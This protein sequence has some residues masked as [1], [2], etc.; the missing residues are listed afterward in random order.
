[1]VKL[2][3]EPDDNSTGPAS[4]IMVRL[5]QTFKSI[6]FAVFLILI[7]STLSLLGTLIS[8][9][10]AE[11]AADPS[12]YSWWLENVAYSKFGSWT[13]I[14]KTLGF[15]N[16]FH[17]FLFLAA[18]VL[19]MLNIIVCTAGRISKLR[20]NLSMI[21]T[22]KNKDFYTHGDYISELI[23]SSSKFKSFG[24]SLIAILKRY[25]YRIKHDKG[26]GS[27]YLAADKN[28]FSLFGTYAIHLSLLF[29][30][31]G[32]ILG[33]YIGF[34]NTA[35]IIAEDNIRDIGYGT[36]LSLGLESFTDEYWSDGT[37][38]DYRSEVVLFENG[39]EVKHGIIRVNHPLMYKG[40]RFHQMFFGPAVKILV[41][42]SE[43]S[44]LFD[45]N[46]ALP[47]TRISRPLQRPEGSFKLTGTDYA[48]VIVGSA[49]N[50]SDP[51]IGRDEIG[52]EIYKNNEVPIA[53]GV[54]QLGIPQKIAEFE[55]T[56]QE[57]KKYSGLQVSREPGVSLIWAGSFL[58][59]T[60]LVMVF[61]FPQRRIWIAV[62]KAPS[63]KSQILIKLS[64]TKGF[65]AET[66][67]LKIIN[68]IK[69]ELD[70]KERIKE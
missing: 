15:F 54:L 63:S 49:L 35:F 39:E 6:K 51:L 4:S 22:V 25:H 69:T 53:W 31:L 19:L 28:R 59:L 34:R 36:G 52:I 30:V 45:E 27:L 24:L 7:L 68:K 46:V 65:S 5:I 55:F 8:Q 60:G 38:R 40:I 62:Y 41:M 10:P 43:E 56:F 29:F 70:F 23:G 3:K 50:G 1:M 17:S 37:P 11:L 67:F 44:V 21:K 64:S 32:F 16:I 57:L 61:Y 26:D 58:F 48:I 14:L 13:F 20:S 9:V 42:D 47:S 33:S 12:G 2:Q 66:E 18:G